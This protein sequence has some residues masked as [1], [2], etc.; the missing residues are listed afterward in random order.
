MFH[1]FFVMKMMINKSYSFSYIKSQGTL[2]TMKRDLSGVALLS[3]F[4]DCLDFSKTK[5]LLMVNVFRREL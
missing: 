5:Q 3:S 1:S 4:K 2:T